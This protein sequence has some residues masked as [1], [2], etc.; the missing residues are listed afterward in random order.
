[1]PLSYIS[2]PSFRPAKTQRPGRSQSDDEGS[3]LAENGDNYISV[4]DALKLVRD[5]SV[6]TRAPSKVEKA[7]WDRILQ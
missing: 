1:V 4:E 3:D 5:D 6:Q 7:V 2:P